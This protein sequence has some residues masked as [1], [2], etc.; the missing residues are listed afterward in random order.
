MLKLFKVTSQ[1]EPIDQDKVSLVGIK[2]L[3]L[4]LETKV[5]TMQKTFVKY[6]WKF[7]KDELELLIYE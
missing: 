5:S 6:I 7:A 3:P 2:E 4:I 1:N